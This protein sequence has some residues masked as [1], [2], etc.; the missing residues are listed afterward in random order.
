[1]FTIA[2]HFI[3]FYTIEQQLT[4]NMKINNDKKEYFY[5]EHFY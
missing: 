1:M 5:H 3:K 4:V 2:D